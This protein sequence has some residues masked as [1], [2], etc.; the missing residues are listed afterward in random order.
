MTNFRTAETLEQL[1]LLRLEFD[2]NIECDRSLF[3]RALVL[4]SG[5]VSFFDTFHSTYDQVA[6]LFV[7]NFPEILRGPNVAII[8]AIRLRDFFNDIA[9][10][11]ETDTDDGSVDRIRRILRHKVLKLDAVVSADLHV[12][13]KDD[14]V[15]QT[16]AFFGV[17]EHLSSHSDSCQKLH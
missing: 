12:R 4:L 10:K 8:A 11:V 5:K 6:K 1:Q 15:W 14:S 3:N 9:G 7:H 2:I 17:F 13:Q 16:G